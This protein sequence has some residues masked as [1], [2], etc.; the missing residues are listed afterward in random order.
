[1]ATAFGG[2]L[3]TGVLAATTGNIVGGLA[4]SGIASFAAGVFKYAAQEVWTKENA[5]WDWS[6]ALANGGIAAVQG[7]VSFGIGAVMGGAGMWE[8]LK[9]GNRLMDVVSSVTPAKGNL[10]TKAIG[11]G[12]GTFAFLKT[13][14]SSIIGRSLYKSIFTLPWSIFD[15]I[16]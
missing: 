4:F 7:L 13:N 6:T 9:K 3:A 5:S 12:K 15:I 1:M 10:I 8:S 16:V 14:L 11:F 2:A